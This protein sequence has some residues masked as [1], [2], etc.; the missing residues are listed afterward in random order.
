MQEHAAAQ[1]VFPC[2]EHFR[3]LRFGLG[4]EEG[5]D[6]ASRSLKCRQVFGVSPSL[7]LH[8]LES[9]QLNILPSLRGLLY[10]E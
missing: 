7:R 8:G 4:F 5:Y 2:L 6:F 9:S 10:I 3:R 1:E